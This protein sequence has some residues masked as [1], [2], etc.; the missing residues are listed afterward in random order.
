MSYAAPERGSS[1]AKL[2]PRLQ[3]PGGGRPEELGSPPDV[4]SGEAPD[5]TVGTLSLPHRASPL[6]LMEMGLLQTRRALLHEQRTLKKSRHQCGP[7]GAVVLL[8]WL[9]ET[10]LG[11]SREPRSLHWRQVLAGGSGPL[12]QP[13]LVGET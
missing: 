12:P 2:S 7:P 13:K 8:G 11:E 3:V 10:S 6:D 9:P 1:G 4:S 5:W